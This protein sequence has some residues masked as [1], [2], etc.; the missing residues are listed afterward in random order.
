MSGPLIDLIRVRSCSV[1][2]SFLNTSVKAKNCKFFYCKFY[3]LLMSLIALNGKE[4]T[5]Q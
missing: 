5:T 2:L 1:S 3:V 4:H